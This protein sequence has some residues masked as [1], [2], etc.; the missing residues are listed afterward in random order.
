MGKCSQQPSGSLSS[1]AERAS[2]RKSSGYQHRQTP[3]MRAASSCA[4]VQPITM[5][6]TL[7]SGRHTCG[8]G[9]SRPA[10]WAKSSARCIARRSSASRRRAFSADTGTKAFSVVTVSFRREKGV[11]PVFS[12]QRCASS[13]PMARVF[14]GETSSPVT[15]TVLCPSQAVNANGRPGIAVSAMST[16]MGGIVSAWASASCRLSVRRNTSSPGLTRMSGRRRSTAISP[17]GVS[18]PA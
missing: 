18:F 1:P 6:G 15:V 16:G 2:S 13:T 17:A 7:P 12:R 10:P 4:R 11:S 3:S 14:A 5:S 8:S 9:S